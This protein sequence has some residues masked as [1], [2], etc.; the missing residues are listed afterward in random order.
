MKRPWQLSAKAAFLSLSQIFMVH[1]LEPVPVICLRF[2]GLL[3]FTQ[4]IMRLFA[5]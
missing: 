5:G 1:S 3:S 4:H 2:G